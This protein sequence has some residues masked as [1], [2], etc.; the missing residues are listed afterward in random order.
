MAEGIRV[1]GIVFRALGGQVVG[2]NGGEMLVVWNGG[3]DCN[4]IEV[5][6]YP[7]VGKG[8]RE[9]IGVLRLICG[10]FLCQDQFRAHRI[11][12]CLSWHGAFRCFEGRENTEGP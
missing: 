9:W 12:N 7:W 1:L 4:G 3:G 8:S 10:R 5:M 6:L 11:R 2:G